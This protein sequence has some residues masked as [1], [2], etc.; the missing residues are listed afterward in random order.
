MKSKLDKN[1]DLTKEKLFYD[2]KSLVQI[3]QNA[4]YYGMTEQQETDYKKLTLSMKFKSIVHN[5]IFV[6]IF[7]CVIII[8]IL[9][10][11][12]TYQLK[13]HTLEKTPKKLEEDLIQD[14][15]KNNEGSTNDNDLYVIKLI[16]FKMEEFI[17]KIRN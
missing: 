7:I 12:L 6:Q 10:A 8:S 11:I 5:S 9:I 1:T 14:I 17:K 13:L 3:I 2:S 15:N 4:V 16:D